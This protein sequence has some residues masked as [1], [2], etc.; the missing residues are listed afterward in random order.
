[1]RKVNKPAITKTDIANAGFTG[2]YVESVYNLIS[3]MIQ[4]GHYQNDREF[5]LNK[6]KTLEIV[7]GIN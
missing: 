2:I 6:L 7:D 3:D 5:L 4:C 1:M